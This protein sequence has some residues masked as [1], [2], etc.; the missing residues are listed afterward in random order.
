[1]GL[2]CVFSLESH[3]D[4]LGLLILVLRVVQSLPAVK[5]GSPGVSLWSTLWVRW[6][7]VND[8]LD[9]NWGTGHY[10]LRLRVKIGFCPVDPS[11]IFLPRKTMDASDPIETRGIR[12]LAQTQDGPHWDL[13]HHSIRW[14]G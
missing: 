12:T 13:F 10:G 14:S 1:M 7:L 5:I 11:I 4:P 3:F 2:V 9:G 6:L 8:G